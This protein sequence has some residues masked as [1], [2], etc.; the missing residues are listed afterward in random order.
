MSD[1]SSM[2]IENIPLETKVSM[3]W[4]LS[5]PRFVQPPCRSAR[6]SQDCCPAQDLNRFSNFGSRFL[7]LNLQT[8]LPPSLEETG[9]TNS[10]SRV[11]IDSNNFDDG[12]RV[13]RIRSATALTARKESETYLW[14]LLSPRKPNDISNF[15]APFDVLIQFQFH[16]DSQNA[17]RRPGIPIRLGDPNMINLS[18]SF[19][20]DEVWRDVRLET[21]LLLNLYLAS[22]RDGL[23]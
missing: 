2:T 5:L 12:R 4:V 11:L 15:R 20:T 16:R 9:I 7:P 22:W 3:I 17:L 13:Y 10:S 8:P 19:I 1:I 18:V 14:N 23:G 21:T 6:D